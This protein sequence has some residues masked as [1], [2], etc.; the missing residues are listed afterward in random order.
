MSFIR[1]QIKQIRSGG[2]PVLWRKMCAFPRWFGTTRYG[3]RL[4]NFACKIAVTLK[5]DWAKAHERLGDA[6]LSLNRFEEGIAHWRKAISLQTDDRYA[7]LYQRSLTLLHRGKADAMMDILWM[8]MEAQEEFAQAHQL[9]RL[10]IRFLREWT[11]AIGHMALLDIYVKM[12]ILGWRPPYRPIVLDAKPA[13]R[14]YLDYWRRYLPDLITDPEAV[15]LLT[16]LAIRLEDHMHMITFADSK[17]MYFTAAAAA[18]QEKWEAEGRSPLLTLTES[19]HERGRGCLKRLGVPPDAWFVSLHVRDTGSGNAR[20]SDINT[21]RMAIESIVAWGG[22]VIRMGEPS[23]PPLPPMPQVIDYAHSGARSDWMDVFLWARCRFFIGTRSGP[24]HVPP[25]FGIPCV[26][27]NSFPMAMPFP[28]QSIGIYKLYQREKEKRLLSFGEACASG[29]GLSES[30]NYIASLGIRLV[31]NTPEEINDVVLEM[32]ER[33]EGTLEYSTED[34]QLQERFKRLKPNFT[35][36]FGISAC[37]VG[38]A[39]LRKYAH[40]L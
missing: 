37:R 33:L 3:S 15:K 35:N 12:G 22:W 10:G 19:D 36:R 30:S 4:V 5:P 21:Y 20:D 8:G 40:L 34:E 29:V 6:L 32:L 26:L 25:T 17:K 39:F 1:Q 9:N 11:C 31:D 23:M 16:P 24:A 13:N 7:Q 28:Y 18:V 14:C 38:R 2:M 27:T